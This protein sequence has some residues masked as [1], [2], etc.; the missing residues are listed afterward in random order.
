MPQAFLSRRGFNLQR[1][2]A[3]AHGVRAKYA[4]GCRCQP[5]RT[6]NTAYEKER[7]Y[8]RQTGDWNGLVNATKARNHLRQLSSDGVGR[9][10]VSD[11]SGISDSV[12]TEIRAGRKRKIRARTER[13]ILA[14]TTGHALPGAR[15]SAVVTRDR[16]AWLLQEG[17][18]RA[19]IARRIGKKTPALQL[20]HTPTITAENADRVERVWRE[21]QE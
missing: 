12:L 10:S 17:F 7:N 18:T 4:Y 14:I 13:R 9:R 6:A 11:C 3:M 20:G 2:E 15:I 5:C 8:K 1:F 19:E 16:I 21:F